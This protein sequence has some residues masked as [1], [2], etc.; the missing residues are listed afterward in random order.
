MTDTKDTIVIEDLGKWS[1]SLTVDA[2]G[3]H[4]RQPIAYDGVLVY[5]TEDRSVSD[6]ANSEY[7]LSSKQVVNRYVSN[8]DTEMDT[9]EAMR[10]VNEAVEQRDHEPVECDSCGADVI[11]SQTVYRDPRTGRDHQQTV[12]PECGEPIDNAANGQMV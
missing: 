8:S 11:P 4:A 2:D 9:I 1:W 7:G 5:S 6:R 10:A 3:V 12:C